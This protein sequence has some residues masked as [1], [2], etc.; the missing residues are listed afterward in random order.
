[1][2]RFFVVL[3]TFFALIAGGGG[4][5][6]AV[7]DPNLTA[8]NKIGIHVLDPNEVMEAAKLVNGEDGAWGYVTVPIQATDRNREKWIRFMRQAAE[9]RVIPI[10]RVATVVSGLHWDE[11]NNYDLVDF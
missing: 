10:V 4:R 1:M 3:V 5:V 9:N 8:N 2:K 11:P 6:I 7:E